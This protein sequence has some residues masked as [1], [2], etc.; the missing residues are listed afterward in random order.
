MNSLLLEL[1]AQKLQEKVKISPIGSVKGI[2]GREFKIDGAKLIKIIQDNGID[3]ALN[4]NH[5]GGEAYGWFDCNSLELREDGIYASLELTQKGDEL[6]KSK[7]FR[8]LS[9]EYYTDKNKNVVFLEGLGLVNQPN[10]LNKA[11]NRIKTFFRERNFMEENLEELQKLA[12]EAEAK[13]QS[14]GE[15]AGKAV[16][17]ANEGENPNNELEN[18]KKENEELKA[19]LAELSAKLENALNQSEKELQENHK[20][21]LDL[22]LQNGSILPSRYA[23]AINMKGQVLE[24]YLDVCKKEASIVLG[25]KDLNFTQQ[26]NSLSLAE[27]K[28]FKQLGIKGDK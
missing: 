21:R 7:A 24:D 15:E 8:Y 6:V 14:I 22:L 27:E 3:L 11:L 28:V 13:A 26:K 18:L 2:D 19:Q 17:S 20:K 9:P 4:L 16:Q 5:Q 23:K 1:N 25:R 12:E 10:L